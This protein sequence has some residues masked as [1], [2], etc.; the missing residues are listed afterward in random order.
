M[1][2]EQI[3]KITKNLEALTSW[4]DDFDRQRSA[5]DYPQGIEVRLDDHFDLIKR[6]TVS[7]CGL[8]DVLSAD[9]RAALGE[10]K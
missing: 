5:W 9:A 8:M 2:E 1:T 7:L 10:T 4:L 6:T 3:A